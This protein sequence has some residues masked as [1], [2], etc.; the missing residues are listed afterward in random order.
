MKAL[1]APQEMVWRVIRDSERCP[2]FQEMLDA[3]GLASKSNLYRIIEC[4]ERKG[5]VKRIGETRGGYKM[6]RGLI[7]VDPTAETTRTPLR[8]YATNELLDELATR[9]HGKQLTGIAA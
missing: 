9:L 4:L 2:T 3:T 6:A 1:T 7:A 8:E 5:Y